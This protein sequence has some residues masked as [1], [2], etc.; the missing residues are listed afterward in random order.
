MHIELR[1][2][3]RVGFKPYWFEDIWR[4]S[5]QYILSSG[6][7]EE[8][9]SNHTDLRTSEEWASNTY[10]VQDIWKSGYEDSWKSGFLYL[11]EDER[12]EVWVPDTF[13]VLEEWASDSWWDKDEWVSD[14][15][16]LRRVRVGVHTGTYWFEDR[17]VAKVG[18]LHWTWG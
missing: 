1:T 12:F 8:W 18:T 9:V 17:R 4:V 13:R 10:W 16:I 15:Y 6:H 3:G 11:F 14:Q 5:F 2:F 7:L